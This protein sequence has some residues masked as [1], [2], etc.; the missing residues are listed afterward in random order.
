MLATLPGI[1][2]RVADQIIA[3]L[4]VTEFA[5]GDPDRPAGT[6][7]AGVPIDGWS[8]PQRDALEVMVAA[9]ATIRPDAQR[10]LVPRNESAGSSGSH[11]R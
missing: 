5:L 2:K 3:E 4:K 6:Q 7:T 1:G 11:T 10:W 8:R 9:L